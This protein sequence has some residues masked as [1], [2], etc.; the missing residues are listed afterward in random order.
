M[1]GVHG[2]MKTPSL[3]VGE[4][5]VVPGMWW[6]FNCE[7]LTMVSWDGIQVEKDVLTWVNFGE[8]IIKA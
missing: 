1:E 5:L 4:V 2:A 3:V 6:W 8:K 7:M